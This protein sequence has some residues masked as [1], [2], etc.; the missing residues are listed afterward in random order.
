MT[1]QPSPMHTFQR[2]SLVYTVIVVLVIVAVVITFWLTYKPVNFSKYEDPNT[3]V[4]LLY[5][6][7][8]E[9]LENLAPEVGLIIAFRGPRKDEFVKFSPNANVSYIV[10]KKQLSLPELKQV[11]MQAMSALFTKH[12]KIVVDEEAMVAGHRGYKLIF[13]GQGVENPNEYLL[14]WT[15]VGDH[16]YVFTY[17][18]TVE[19][20]ND[21]LGVANTMLRSLK[22]P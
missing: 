4:S 17:A 19:N 2:K 18:N 1:T 11:T 14:A 9:V 8:W 12:I 21:Y 5:P 22:I 20:F 3:G 7:S 15:Q 6:T 13:A 10:M 16:V